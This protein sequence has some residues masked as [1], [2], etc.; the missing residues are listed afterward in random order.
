MLGWAGELIC[1]GNNMSLDSL[2]NDRGDS[3]INRALVD[4][5]DVGPGAA[6]QAFVAD[7]LSMLHTLSKSRR[8]WHSAIEYEVMEAL[9][10]VIPLLKCVT[11]LCEF[12]K[13]LTFDD[14]ASSLSKTVRRFIL[15]APRVCFP[16]ES[17]ASRSCGVCLWCCSPQ[18][19][20]WYTGPPLP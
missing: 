19:L 12:N 17:L 1:G 20:A 2:G 6:N 8:A 16:P 5:C 4:P 9:R 11:D 3:S 10:N 15:S 7:L 14:V 13:D 18:R